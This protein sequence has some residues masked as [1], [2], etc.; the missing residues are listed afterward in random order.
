MNIFYTFFE[1]TSNAKTTNA[2]QAKMDIVVA[3]V[4]EILRRQRVS[5]LCY[6]KKVEMES[7]RIF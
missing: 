7:T 6:L 3:R 1:T 5:S 4:N 2:L